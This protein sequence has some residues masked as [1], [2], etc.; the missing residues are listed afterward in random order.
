MWEIVVFA[1]NPDTF[2]RVGGPGC[3]GR[4]RILN[5]EK[6]WEKYLKNDMQTTAYN[7]VN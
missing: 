1:A 5:N 7:T 6:Q 3:W 2:L 4:T